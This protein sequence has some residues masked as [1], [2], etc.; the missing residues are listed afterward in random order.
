MPKNSKQTVKKAV[1]KIEG[2]IVK[3]LS[4]RPKKRNRRKR[5]IQPTKIGALLRTAGTAAG[6]YFGAPSLGRQMG[7]G[8]S[9]I[10]GQG[11]YVVKS[12]NTMSAGVPTF[13]PLNSG[14][15]LQFREYIKDISS[16][17]AFSSNNFQINPGLANMFPWLSQIAVNFEE[18]KIHGLVVYLNSLSAT[19]VSST[20]TALGLWGCVTQYD[21]SEPPFLNKQACENYVGCQTA[22][23]SCS[24]LHSIECKNKANVLDKYFVRSGDVTSDEDLKFYDIGFLQVFSQGAQQASNIGEMWV[25]YDIEFFKPRLPLGNQNISATFVGTSDT[26]IS[27]FPLGNLLSDWS[28]TSG[29][30]L[31]VE[32]TNTNT[33][34]IDGTAPKGVYLVQAMWNTSLNATI[35]GPVLTATNVTAVN[36]FRYPGLSNQSSWQSQSAS[37]NRV[38][39]ALCFRKVGELDIVLTFPNITNLTIGAVT[40]IITKLADGLTQIKPKKEKLDMSEIDKLRHLLLAIDDDKLEEVVK[41]ISKPRYMIKNLEEE[42]DSSPRVVREII[43]DSSF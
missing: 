12:P 28:V 7:A 2:Q 34:T 8:I 26:A 10:F 15:R 21:P 31:P 32:W 18:Y 29:S 42:K 4:A 37:Q 19:A 5:N 3:N 1:Q 41:Y 30:N 11:D 16:S 43:S 9:R 13:S 39:S 23:P 36:I 40:V 25:S 33:L 6:A 20:N 17:I 38:L 24:V 35:A 22:V 14:F 27:T